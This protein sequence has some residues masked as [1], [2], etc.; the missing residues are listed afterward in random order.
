MDGTDARLL[1]ALA[2]DPRATIMSLAG[3]LGISR[4][5]VQ[6]RL[7]RIE[8]ADTL[9]SFERRVSP[10]ALGYQLTAF[11]DATVTQQLLDEVA[12]ALAAIPEVLEV[13]G[14]SGGVDLLIR[15]AARDAD[16]LYRVAG[17]ILATRGIERTETALVM[18]NL[19]DYRVRPLL[20]RLARDDSSARR[21]S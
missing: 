20:S 15:V 16:D 13:F 5:T 1:M 8:G 3:T 7:A 6:A 21:S 19:V 9:S 12:D 4:N 11:I 18:R 17:R 14:I 2:D 10:Q